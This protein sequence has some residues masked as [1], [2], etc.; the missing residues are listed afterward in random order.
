MDS[1]RL[2]L[3][4]IGKENVGKT[5]IVSRF[6]KDFFN[7]INGPTIGSSYVRKNMEINNRKIIL[8][9]WDTAGQE[10]YEGLMPMYYRDADIILLTYDII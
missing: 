5:C 3:V 6:S 4:M 2:K 9:I 1:I 8:N 10:R 7:D